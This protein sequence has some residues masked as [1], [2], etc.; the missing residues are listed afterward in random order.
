MQ[1]VQRWACRC[2]ALVALAGCTAP[3]AP[4][5]I[6][7]VTHINGIPVEEYE[8]NRRDVRRGFELTLATPD[9][10]ASAASVQT[11]SAPSNVPAPQRA[12]APVTPAPSNVTAAAASAGGAT[13]SA[14]STAASAASDGG[15]VVAGVAAAAA[16][17]FAPIIVASV[18]GA[19]DGNALSSTTFVDDDTVRVTLVETTSGQ[20][21]SAQVT[22]LPPPGT[23]NVYVSA[24]AAGQ[25]NGA[26]QAYA[27]VCE[28]PLANVVDWA[29]RG[30]R[31]EPTSDGYR[32]GTDVCPGLWKFAKV[33]RT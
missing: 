29:N 18:D 14:A 26:L 20:P 16:G 32:L 19:P 2:A 8:P 9:T 13:V 17:V 33:N 31:I 30:G 27:A 12:A 23:V 10:A 11:I 25:V 24:L 1:R 7:N 6:E 22:A 15:S 4:V 5:V 3:V 21:V 28:V